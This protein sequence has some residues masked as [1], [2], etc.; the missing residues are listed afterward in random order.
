[1]GGSFPG[2][3]RRRVL[4]L[5]PVLDTDSL[6]PARAGIHAVRQTAR[7]LG[8]DEAAGVEVRVTGNVALN[9]EEMLVIARQALAATGLSFVVVGFVLAMALGSGRLVLNILATL[10]VGLIWTA[11][12]A[13]WAVG[14]VNMISIAF[15]VL[16][17]GLGVDFGIHICMRYSE[18]VRSG[19]AHAEALRETAG[20]VGG[21][22]LLCT[23]TTAT[24]FYVFV[25]TDYSGI[26]ELGL[27]SGTG[28]FVSFF[29][30]MTFLPA[31]MS[32]GSVIEART[33]R[34]AP[35]WLGDGLLRFPV[36]RARLVRNVALVLGLGAAALL[37]RARFDHNLVRLRDPSTE[38]AQTFDDLLAASATS[39]WRARGTHPH[40]VEDGANG[41]RRLDR[42]E[43][44]DARSPH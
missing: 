25:P 12:F 43:P 15:G 3:P 37:P 34:R 7:S 40:A 5:Q 8:L 28:M 4:I 18:L 35:R 19:S 24:G 42:G 29:L 2:E 13:A 27:I 26:A 10:L 1:M 30:S 44:G 14:S 38:S 36:R 32:L 41:L 39:P 20:G 21:S 11:S 6:L 17:I 9:Y 31:L 16:F 22:L 33:M 23:V